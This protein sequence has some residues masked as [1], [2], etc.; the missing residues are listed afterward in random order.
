MYLLKN[1]IYDDIFFILRSYSYDFINFNLKV[2]INILTLVLTR[3][4]TGSVQVIG[5]ELFNIDTE[6]FD[7]LQIY[8]NRIIYL[9]ERVNNI[10]LRIIE[11][12][13]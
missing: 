1:A 7:F 6:L 8:F 2:L 3:A 10:S 13:I 9:Y 12:V 5:I 4:T 11:N